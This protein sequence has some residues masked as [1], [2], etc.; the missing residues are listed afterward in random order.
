M[1][2]PPMTSPIMTSSADVNND[3]LPA[4]TDL[5]QR[6]LNLSSTN[7]LSFNLFNSTVHENEQLL[8]SA[9]ERSELLTQNYKYFEQTPNTA[10]I[11]EDQTLNEEG[12][13]EEEE[14]EEGVEEKEQGVNPF[15]R[16]VTEEERSHM[17]RRKQEA[18]KPTP[19]M[20]DLLGHVTLIQ[21]ELLRLD[22]RVR[23]MLGT[24]GM[25]GTD[26]DG[27]AGKR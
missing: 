12:G 1:T 5:C 23:S 11:Q 7:Q 25:G 3:T 13:E 26:Q 2:S 21:E 9:H 16:N 10:H 19:C 24:I 6:C 4:C 8:A 22:T 17:R 27:I 14:E 18:L 20:R 15:G